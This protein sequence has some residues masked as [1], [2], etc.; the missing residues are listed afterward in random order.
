MSVSPKL[1]IHISFQDF[2]FSEEAVYPKTDI[3][4]AIFLN[5]NCIDKLY[6]NKDSVGKFVL[7]NPDD[8][9]RFIFRSKQTGAIIGCISFLLK[10]FYSHIDKQF[11]Q[12]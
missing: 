1:S 3:A 7:T 11:T 6:L 5:E 4:C 8:K 9:L 2:E 10:A 12:W